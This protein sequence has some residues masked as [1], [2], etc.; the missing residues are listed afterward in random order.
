MAGQESGLQLLDEIRP[1][2]PNCQ[3]HQSWDCASER[4]GDQQE[5][6]EAL[7]DERR[8]AFKSL[9]FRVEHCERHGE[10]FKVVVDP[11]DDKSSLDETLEGSVAKWSTARQGHANVLSIV[12]EDNL[13]T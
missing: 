2:D 4:L 9:R 10:F 11:L 12:P 5:I 3:F 13:V 1:S 8:L 6:V 7:E